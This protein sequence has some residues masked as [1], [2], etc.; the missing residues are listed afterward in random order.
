MIGCKR[1][2]QALCGKCA[3]ERSEQARTDNLIGEAER[4]RR[5]L[6]RITERLAAHVGELQALTQVYARKRQEGPGG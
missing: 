6:T 5:E 3:P 2:V 4:T 1:L